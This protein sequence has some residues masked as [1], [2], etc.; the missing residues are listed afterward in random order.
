MPVSPDP[1]SPCRAALKSAA[2][3]GVSERRAEHR[4]LQLPHPP[5]PD[6]ARGREEMPNVWLVHH[7]QVCPEPHLLALLGFWWLYVYLFLYFG[8]ALQH[9]GILVP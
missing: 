4:L 3:A 5:F 9:V 7:A 8:Q 2:H 1:V 6:C